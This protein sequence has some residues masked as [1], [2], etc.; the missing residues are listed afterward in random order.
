MAF[1]F[2]RGT[3]GRLLGALLGVPVAFTFI[4]QGAYGASRRF[5]GFFPGLATFILLIGAGVVVGMALLGWFPNWSATKRTL[6][7][8]LYAGLMT[9][10]L[11]ILQ[12][13]ISCANGDCL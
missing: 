6:A 3:H 7:V 2:Q 13:L 5:G 10:V 4:A 9:V 1:E 12:G 11:V 8:A